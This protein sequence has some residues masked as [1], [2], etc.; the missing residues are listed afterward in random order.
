MK[1]LLTA[2]NAKYIHSN[3]A[4]YTLQAYA[5]KYKENVELAE[6]TI[7]NYTDEI[8]QQ[9]YKKTPDVIAF[10]CYIWNIKIIET[11]ACE[12][13]KILPQAKIWLGGPEVSY[14][15]EET[16]ERL[17]YIDGIMIG[18]GE[19]TFLELMEYYMERRRSLTDI[20]GIV[21][22]S[23]AC[24]T[25]TEVIAQ[26]PFTNQ[27]I[28]TSPREQ[29]DLSTIPFPYENIEEFKNK[30]IYYETSRGCPYSCSYCLSSIDKRVRFRNVE[31]VKQE[32]QCFLDQK[33]P[34]VK[35]VDRT[36]NCNKNHAMEIWNYLKNH[37]NGITN[38]HFEISA[39]ILDSEELE[40]LSS[41]RPGLA[42]LEIGVQSTNPVTITAINRKMNLEKLQYAVH[43]IN[44]AENIHQHL[45]LIAGLPY[46]DYE[47]FQKSFNTV[48]ALKPEQFQLG[49][50]KVLKGSDMYEESKKR[51]IIYKSIPP[52]EVLYT[53]WLNYE[54]VLNLKAVEEMIEVY[55]NSGQFKNTVEYLLHFHKTP[56]D[57][58]HS[59]SNYYERKHLN[60]ISQ[61]RISRYHILLEYYQEAIKEEAGAIKEILL[62]DLY[63]RENLKSRPVFAGD[64]SIYKER[65][66][67][68]YL[69]EENQKKY[70][71]NYDGVQR[72]QT[73]SLTHIEHFGID[74]GKTISQGKTYKKD[75]F[76]LFDYQKRNP[77]NYEAATF[78]LD[79]I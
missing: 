55:Y 70:L 14:D 58:Y 33:V 20:K 39:D 1:V 4:L 50:L 79:H 27:I 73:G 66:R 22:Q 41:F 62:Y 37:D 25:P 8:L 43:K 11:I 40:L 49:F 24:M 36:F 69:E 31:L 7:N 26:L 23:S 47:T 76:I 15:A 42:Q 52:Y 6:F 75:C 16:I 19:A 71:E 54:E 34:Q 60:G 77:L 64:N 12:L 57:M 74:I 29:L 38:F 35:F 68:F 18:E 5:S 13:R 56:F 59:L 21:F 10:S 61:S 63:L 67:K 53:K 17:T 78:Y 32:L 44:E 48:Y 46:E 65:Y 9:I 28:A 2:V 3:L 72:K 51:T 45:D 30:I